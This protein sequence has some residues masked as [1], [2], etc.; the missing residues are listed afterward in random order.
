[1]RTIELEKASSFIIIVYIIIFIIVIIIQLILC[2]YAIPLLLFC[3][4]FFE[5][6]KLY[7][8]SLFQASFYGKFDNIKDLVKKLV[9]F[10]KI[11][12]LWLFCSLQSGSN[13]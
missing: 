4:Y 2:L 10:S 11:L 1:M 3:F 13:K 7:L 12:Y 6:F 5:G 8:P 9:I